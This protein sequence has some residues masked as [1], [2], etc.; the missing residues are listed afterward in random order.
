MT[1][2]DALLFVSPPRYFGKFIS[3]TMKCL[4]RGDLTGKVSGRSVSRLPVVWELA[5]GLAPILTEQQMD[6][7]RN[8]D[9]L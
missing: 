6:S 3:H 7:G 8:P 1:P 4:T 2:D 9:W 5:V